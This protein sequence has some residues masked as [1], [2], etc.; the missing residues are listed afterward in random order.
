M[1]PQKQGI[2]TQHTLLTLSPIV[3]LAIGYQ[4]QG[5]FAYIPQESGTQI[6]SFKLPSLNTNS[7]QRSIQ[8]QST[9]E[10]PQ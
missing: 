2:W 3:N 10:G 5:W 9:P 7:V 1:T 8:V 6:R 4:K